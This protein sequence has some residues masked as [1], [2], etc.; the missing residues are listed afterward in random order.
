M[1]SYIPGYIS[2]RQTGRPM[3]E[4]HRFSD[5]CR[6]LSAVEFRQALQMGKTSGLTLVR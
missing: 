4:A 1:H 2:A 3:G 5:L 6:P